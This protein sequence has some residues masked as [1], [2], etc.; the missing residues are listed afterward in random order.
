MSYWR[1][2]FP[3]TDFIF[4]SSQYFFSHF[5][6][7]TSYFL[8]RWCWCLFCTRPTSSLKQQTTGRHDAP[9]IFNSDPELTSL[10]VYL[11]SLCW[12]LSW[13][14][15]KT[16]LIFFY[17]R[18]TIYSIW[19]G[20]LYSSHHEG[21]FKMKA[22]IRLQNIVYHMVNFHT[23]YKIICEFIPR[24]GIK[25]GHTYLNVQGQIDFYF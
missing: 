18:Y 25:L 7:S 9:L 20:A 16:N 11:S 12:V 22:G 24:S 13:E 15:I 10:W 19:Y 17:F 8:I 1:G 5:M 2:T 21:W 3:S 6:V 14:V 23:V 4:Y